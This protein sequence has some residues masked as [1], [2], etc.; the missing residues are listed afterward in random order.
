MVNLVKHPL[1]K[2]A[3]S[4]LAYY[5]LIPYDYPFYLLGNHSVVYVH[6][7][8]TA[9]TSIR[10]TLYFE[11]A[12]KEPP[13]MDQH[14]MAREILELMGQ[15]KWSASFKFAFVRNPWARLHSLHR[16][17][18]KHG[19]IA[20]ELVD[21]FPGYVD[22]ILAFSEQQDPSM[23]TKQYFYPQ[24]KWLDAGDCPVDFV[25]R[26]EQLHEDFARLCGLIGET[27]ELKKENVSWPPVSYRSAYSDELAERVGHYYRSDIERFGYAF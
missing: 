22:R 5:K 23:S 20:P 27:A 8:K 2:R 7:P 4:T 15:E 10:E 6:I 26:F 11:P 14:H 13:E 24:T 25:G 3:R 16:H 9:G 18:G 1:V 19:Y 21:D 12:R 17:G